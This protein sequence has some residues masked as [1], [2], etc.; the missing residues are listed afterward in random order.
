MENRDKLSVM[1]F[2]VQEARKFREKV[3]PTKTGHE[4][5]MNRSRNNSSPTTETSNEPNQSFQIE[6]LFN[7][8]N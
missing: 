6:M 3:P 4:L 2:V 8:S 5:N 1:L 7:E